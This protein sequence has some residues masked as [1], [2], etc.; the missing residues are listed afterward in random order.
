MPSDHEVDAP[1][2][3]S[4]TPSMIRSNTSG[5]SGGGKAMNRS[6]GDAVG[7]ECRLVGVLGDRNLLRNADQRE[8]VFHIVPA[9][10]RP[11]PRRSG[12]MIRRGEP[13]CTF[14]C[15]TGSGGRDFPVGCGNSDSCC[16]DDGIPLV[17]HVG[18]DASLADACPLHIRPVSLRWGDWLGPRDRRVEAVGQVVLAADQIVVVSALRLVRGGFL[19]ARTG[20]DAASAEARAAAGQLSGGL[21]GVAW[22]V[23]RGGGV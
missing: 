14:R 2:A 16:E 19:L 23:G 1:K 8:A 9:G 3:A 5:S 13:M 18:R 7:V 12:R 17:V 22:G 21:G 15:G 4:R 10:I 20:S 11:S 6:V